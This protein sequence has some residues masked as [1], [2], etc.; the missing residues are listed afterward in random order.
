MPAFWRS[1]LA[2]AGWAVQVERPLREGR[3]VAGSL[4]R[5]EK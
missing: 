1:V 2:A 3:K 4:S 5:C